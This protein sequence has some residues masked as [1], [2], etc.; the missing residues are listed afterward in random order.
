M[1]LRVVFGGTFVLLTVCKHNNMHELYGFGLLHVFLGVF[2][3]TAKPYKKNWM[4]RSDGLILLLVGVVLLI[5]MYEGKILFIFV[6]V[7]VS[8]NVCLRIIFHK[9]LKK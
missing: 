5:F 7:V 3:L 2:F 6:A 4:N 1:L 8:V 9:C